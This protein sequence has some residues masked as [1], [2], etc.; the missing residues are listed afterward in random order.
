MAETIENNLRRVIIDEQPINPKYYE[1]MSELLDTLIQE[2]KASRRWTT[3]SIWRKIVEL[4]RQVKNPASEH[5]LPRLA[6]HARQTRLYDNLGRIEQLALSVDSAV[7]GTGRMIGGTTG[8]RPRWS[9]MRSP[10][11]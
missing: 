1:K 3:R 8:S 10:A 5:E 11:C 9:G 7:V 6:E 4:T 2:R